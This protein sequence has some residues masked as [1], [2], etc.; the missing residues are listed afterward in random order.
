M[1]PEDGRPPES[2]PW[3]G[4]VPHAE[5][6]AI[7]ALPTGT[8]TLHFSDIEESTRLVHV[9]GD[10]YAGVLETHR[11][12]LRAAVAAHGGCEVDTAGDGFFAAFPRATD[13]V[14]AAADAQRGL[15]AHPWPGEAV[16]RVR[17]GLHTG[18]PVATEG[19]YTGM[20]VHRAAR[21]CSAAWG[22]QVL[23]SEATR[24]LV[25]AA[26]LPGGVTVRDLGQSRLR[27]LAQPEQLYQLVIPG[28]PANFPPLR[29][30]VAPPHNLPRPSTPLL[31][32]AS[33]IEAIGA[34]LQGGARLVTLT[35]PGGAGKTRLAQAIGASR[36]GDYPAGTFFIPLAPITDPGL[37]APTIAHVIGVQEQP[38]RDVLDSLKAHLDGQVMLLVLDNFEQVVGAAPVV[39]NLLAACDGLRTLV[40]SREALRLRGEHEFPVP[41]LAVPR[42]QYTHDGAALSQFGA[43]QLFI[44]RA[45]A[46]DPTFA[47]D[48][49]NARSVAEICYRLDGLPLAI[50]LAAARIKVLSPQAMLAR[51]GRPLDLLRG[52]ARDLPARHQTLRQAIAWSYDLLDEA[53]RALFRRLA[54]FAGGC[55]LDAAEAVCAGDGLTI[56]PLDS[57]AALVNK[58]LLLREPAPD[59]EPRFRMLETIREF[60]LEALSAAG[61][62]PAARRTHAEYFLSVAERAAPE[63]AGRGQ[64]TWLDRFEAD[65]DNLRAALHFLE[66]TNVEQALRM[67]VALWRFWLVRGHLSEARLHLE[68]LR[69]LGRKA[70]SQSDAWVRIQNAAGIVTLE[71]G[72][73]HAALTILEEGVAVCRAR[74][75]RPGLATA[76]NHLGWTCMG[77]V[78]LDAARAYSE[79][80][81]AL[82]RELGDQRGVAGALQNLAIPAAGAG[83]FAEAEAMLQQNLTIRQEIGE[84]RGVAYAFLLLAWTATMEGAFI[85]AKAHAADGLVAIRQVGDRQIEATLLT[86]KAM[87][88]LGL[89]SMEEATATLEAALPLWK[90][91]GNRD[92]IGM[93]L[94][95]LGNVLLQREA[96]RGGALLDEG[97][98]YWSGL[99][100]SIWHAH[101]LRI[102]GQIAHDRGD[103]EHARTY[104]QASKSSFEVLGD[105]RA[106]AACLLDLGAAALVAGDREAAVAAC[107]EALARLDTLGLPL[108]SEQLARFGPVLAAVQ[109]P[110]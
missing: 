58:S 68:R 64:A 77:L 30:L 55:T 107:T 10:E 38:G 35:G 21:I 97:Q 18:E 46:A 37:V 24:S 51:L 91:V 110:R 61:D 4:R 63:L 2:L 70:G 9:L 89:G 84:L 94:L 102:I 36:L 14:A 48:N 52:G 93:T 11:R 50:E 85:R 78:R 29:T 22:G 72:D 104:L 6:F 103:Y 79:E 39:A 25:Q 15:A 90:A 60:G 53:E 98:G 105:H 28:L 95:A 40:T 82:Y 20:D 57:I 12:V 41:P 87:A 75:D 8:I 86:Q 42:P 44:Q 43:V 32:R 81:L 7:A 71:Q 56:D 74:G 106:L 47:I 99:K 92:N 83:H 16:V 5:D 108:T 80:A 73:P 49:H 101:P 23:L 96:A 62:G 31:G 26:G 3:P 59:D 27:G 45:Q 33:E 1:A 54:V 76:L 66:E 19:G 69:A 13:A 17:M 88:E 34:L 100:N 67:G 65:Q 109:E